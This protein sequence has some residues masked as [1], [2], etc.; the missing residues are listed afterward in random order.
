MALTYAPTLKKLKS[1]RKVYQHRF[2]AQINCKHEKIKD[3]L[4]DCG[5]LEIDLYML[6]T[7]LA[8]LQ[9]L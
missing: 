5:G 2:E 9:G 6:L 3:N 7:K 4:C 1:V 8:S